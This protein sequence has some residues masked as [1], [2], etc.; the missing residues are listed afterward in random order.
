MLTG[1]RITSWGLVGDDRRPT[2]REE[3]E[4]ELTAVYVQVPEGYIAFVEELPGANTQ[5]AT[6]DEV[7]GTA[8]STNSWL[9]RFVV[10]SG[11]RS[12]DR[13]TTISG[14]QRSTDGRCRRGHTALSDFGTLSR[15]THCRTLASR[16]ST[17]RW[18]D[19]RKTSNLACQKPWNSSGGHSA[20]RGARCKN[21]LPTFLFIAVDG[22]SGILVLAFPESLRTRYLLEYGFLQLFPLCN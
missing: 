1:V 11:F 3:C 19:S 18:G 8:R 5:G 7:H 17:S 4:M 16:R 21:G 20:Q 10:I 9:E 13:R 2:V 22:L 12:V 6:L 14:D 15:N